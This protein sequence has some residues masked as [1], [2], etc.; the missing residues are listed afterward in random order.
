VT[1]SERHRARPPRRSRPLPGASR[2]R[3][4]PAPGQE[5][6]EPLRG[7]APARPAAGRAPAAPAPHKNPGA[8]ATPPEGH[9]KQGKG[10]H[11]T[12]RVKG[13]PRGP[14]PAPRAVP[15]RRGRG[16]RAPAR[17]PI[18]PDSRCPAALAAPSCV[19]PVGRGRPRPPRA[20]GA[21]ASPPGGPTDGP[22]ALPLPSSF[23]PSPTA[24][25]PS[26]SPFPPLLSSSPQAPRPTSYLFCS[27][28][29]CYSRD[30]W[31]R[32]RARVTA[33]TGESVRLVGP[34][35]SRLASPAG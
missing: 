33:P 26:R 23:L 29:T 10:A 21:L 28:P 22:A 13:T 11:T 35:R 14:E 24:A 3:G 2:S 16:R 1:G 7:G 25:L 18:A 17:A 6:E 19:A 34:R 9:T 32:V 8:A 27:R 12:R 31:A 5:G 30:R 4:R 20:P 15:W